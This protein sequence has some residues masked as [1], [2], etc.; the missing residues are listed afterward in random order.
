MVIC[1]IQIIIYSIRRV[2]YQYI[3][4]DPQKKVTHTSPQLVT[5]TRSGCTSS[6]L[7]SSRSGLRVWS[8]LLF[9]K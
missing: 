2:Q 5:A 7:Q 9:K 1:F 4:D 6:H 3:I 8:E